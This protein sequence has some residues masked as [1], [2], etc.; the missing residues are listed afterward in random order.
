MALSGEFMKNSSMIQARKAASSMRASSFSSSSSIIDQKLSSEPCE[1]GIFFIYGSGRLLPFAFYN[2][3]IRK[4]LGME[5][6][7]IYFS[8]RIINCLP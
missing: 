2:E 6:D 3:G 4:Q 5:Y 7:K 1:E 8:I